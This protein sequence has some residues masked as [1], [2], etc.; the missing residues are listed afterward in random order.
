VG[1]GGWDKPNQIKTKQKQTNKQ[2]ITHWEA[3]EDHSQKD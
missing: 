3:R 2:T 1:T